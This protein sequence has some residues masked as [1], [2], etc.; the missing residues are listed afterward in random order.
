MMDEILVNDCVYSDNNRAM[1]W[2]LWKWAI[3]IIYM[4]SER[5]LAMV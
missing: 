2:L 4:V 5:L 1:S 3:Q